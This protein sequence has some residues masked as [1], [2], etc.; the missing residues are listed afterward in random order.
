[1]I[2]NAKLYLNSHR[3]REVVQLHAACAPPSHAHAYQLS[4]LALTSAFI[5]SRTAVPRSH[6]APADTGSPC[7]SAPF[8]PRFT[9]TPPVLPSPCACARPLICAPH[10]LSQPAHPAHTR[11]PHRREGG[12]DRPL[13]FTP[14]ARFG[15]MHALTSTRGLCLYTLTSTLSLTL[16]PFRDTA[17]PLRSHRRRKSVQLRATGATRASHSHFRST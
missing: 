17:F 15:L 7:V 14:V 6:T 8:T 12:T 4:A 2:P 13:S 1:V 3:P 11:P 10:E 5:V 16:Q 9:S